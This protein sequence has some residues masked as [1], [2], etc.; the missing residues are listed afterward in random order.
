MCMHSEG[1]KELK[2]SRLHVLRLI[3]HWESKEALGK[4]DSHCLSSVNGEAFIKK[5]EDK[6]QH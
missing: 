6:G 3:T 5:L 2:V 1:T 4:G